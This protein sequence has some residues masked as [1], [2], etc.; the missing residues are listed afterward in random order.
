MA[1]VCWNRFLDICDAIEEGNVSMMEN[2]DFANTDVPFDVDLPQDNLPVNL[3]SIIY[4][5]WAFINLCNC[6]GTHER[7]STGLGPPGF[8]G[9]K[10]KP[11][12]RLQRLFIMW[13]KD[14]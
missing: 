13:I 12:G 11:R 9:S 14:L 4:L 8:L 6:K 7:R 3:F 10:S 5:S 1:F 2:A